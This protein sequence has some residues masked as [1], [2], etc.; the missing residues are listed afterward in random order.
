MTAP[1]DS[2][3]TPSLDPSR[4]PGQD[5]GTDIGADP[6]G[7][8][9]DPA[10]GSSG[11]AA[12]Y[13]VRARDA[14]QARDALAKRVTQMQR[15]EVERMAAGRIGSPA[16]LWLAGVELADVLDDAGD[17]DPK[18]VDARLEQ[19]LVDRPHWR[20]GVPSFDGGPRGHVRAPGPTFA[21]LLHER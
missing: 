12:R 20:P 11:E 9:Q 19:V 17:V 8:E 13:R 7:Q 4:P 5:I 15:A 1:D 6:A 18:R 3:S 2:T 16:D 14:E 21:D 10:P